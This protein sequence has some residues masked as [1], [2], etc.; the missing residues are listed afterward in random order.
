MA[1]RGRACRIAKN[2][3]REE[4]RPLSSLARRTGATN[5]RVDKM[6]RNGRSAT[7][8]RTTRQSSRDSRG[9]PVRLPFARAANTYSG[10]AA[11]PLSRR[12]RVAN[13]VPDGVMFPA[14]RKGWQV[15]AFFDG[16]RRTS[17][18]AVRLG[19]IRQFTTSAEGVSAGQKIGASRRLPETTWIVIR[20]VFLTIEFSSHRVSHGSRPS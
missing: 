19:E 20:D 8:C 18:V 1:I 6:T 3:T 11:E 12:L 17:P 7:A 5:G 9:S 4:D 10:E 2:P 16:L 13:R 14:L 15:F